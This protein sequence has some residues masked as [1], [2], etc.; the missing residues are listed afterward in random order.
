MPLSRLVSLIFPT[1]AC[2]V[3]YVKTTQ[4]VT[5]CPV[6]LNLISFENKDKKESSY[7]KTYHGENISVI[8]VIHFGRPR[9]KSAITMK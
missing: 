6:R 8:G 5:F 2:G 7:V 3:V 1:T 9:V 4:Y